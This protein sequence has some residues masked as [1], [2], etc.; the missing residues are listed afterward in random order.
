MD[1]VGVIGM[2]ESVSGRSA[3]GVE[4]HEAA[5]IGK[6]SAIIAEGANMHLTGRSQDPKLAYF[7]KNRDYYLGVMAAMLDAAGQ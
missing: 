6:I 7:V 5:Q 1:R 2:W 3:Q 4:W